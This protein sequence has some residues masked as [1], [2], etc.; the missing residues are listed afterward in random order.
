MKIK[1]QKGYADGAF[2]GVVWAM[3]ILGVLIGFVLFVGVPW[4]WNF[5]K[6]FIHSITG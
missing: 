3:I 1:N 6:P 5:I 2:A 4:L